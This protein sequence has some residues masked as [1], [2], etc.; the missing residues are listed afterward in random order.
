MASPFLFPPGGC[1]CNETAIG[2]FDVYGIV[3]TQFGAPPPGGLVRYG[4]MWPEFAQVNLATVNLSNARYHT[5]ERTGW[6]IPPKLPQSATH[7]SL[8]TLCGC[9]DK[10]EY[11]WSQETR[12][13]GPGLILYNAQSKS[14][15]AA[16][17]DTSGRRL[18]FG[19]GNSWSASDSELRVNFS[20]PFDVNPAPIPD[21]DPNTHVYG[22]SA[23]HSI[24]FK[25]GEEPN[26][27]RLWQQFLYE[28]TY[29]HGGERDGLRDGGNRF[30]SILHY[31]ARD[32]PNC[33]GVCV[34]QYSIH[35]PG[36]PNPFNYNRFWEVIYWRGKV[37]FNDTEIIYPDYGDW[38][39]L[40]RYYT[41]LPVVSS[42][43]QADAYTPLMI[44]ADSLKDGD[45]NYAILAFPKEDRGSG[46]WEIRTDHKVRQH[47]IVIRDDAIKEEYS[48][49]W[50][51]RG[52]PNYVHPI[53][54][55][56]QND[57]LSAIGYSTSVGR[58][59]L[60]QNGYLL[61]TRRDWIEPPSN[62][63]IGTVADP[64]KPYI[65]VMYRSG[66]EVW[67][68]P[69]QLTIIPR[70]A[71]D[72]WFYLWWGGNTPSIS[73]R[74]PGKD[75]LPHEDIVRNPVSPGVWY[76]LVSP[77]GSRATPVGQ[78]KYGTMTIISE[79]FLT[80]HPVDQIGIGPY[81]CVKNSGAFDDTLPADPADF[82]QALRDSTS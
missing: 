37:D 70:M 31:S 3:P 59:V 81:D 55:L 27:R 12:S 53:W 79:N 78:L 71:G 24:V 62:T 25:K 49:L 48:Y 82:E 58:S 20:N 7:T 66:N 1:C 61:Q 2:C 34:S 17:S 6:V 45:A 32:W 47:V 38:T 63:H 8:A 19:G 30:V 69:P 29:Y 50:Q 23:W 39:E 56:P 80:P 40:Y 46:D 75:Y 57:F 35:R 72:R 42:T 11:V 76:W 73:T 9:P 13:N 5:G 10:G 65:G 14:E 28:R 54:S 4:V 60:N 26:S 21:Y 22:G 74:L 33:F 77:D 41:F 68:T 52:N 16:F 18:N 15:L 51:D 67:R 43:S 36:D 64:A 44:S